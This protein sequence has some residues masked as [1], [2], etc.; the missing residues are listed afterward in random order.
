MKSNQ[1]ETKCYKRRINKFE[2]RLTMGLSMEPVRVLI[3]S[4]IPKLSNRLNM[5]M[6]THLYT[7]IIEYKV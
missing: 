6:G 5:K 2:V 7:K 4:V 1:I 3:F